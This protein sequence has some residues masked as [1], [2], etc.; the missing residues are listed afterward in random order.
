MRRIKNPWVGKKEYFC[1]GCCPDNKDGVRMKFYAD[2]DEV[3]SVWH[4]ERQF[5]GWIDTLHGGIQAVMLDEICAWAVILKMNTTG[6]T[7]KM[8]TRYKH[9][10]STN[11]KYL[12]VR[13]K[14]TDVHR[15]LATIEATISDSN[16]NVCSTATCTY[17]TFAIEKAR[18]M[19]MQELELED[20]EV[21]L[22]EITSS[23]S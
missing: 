8:E 23:I 15:N 11:D 22:E 6:V 18:E 4:P 20:K 16:G 5:Q 7:A 14:V 2:G 19:G 17:F 12:I 10:I 3:I 1:F 9:S 13:A 21:T